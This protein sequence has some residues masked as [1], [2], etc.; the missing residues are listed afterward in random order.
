[1][2]AASIMQSSTSSSQERRSL[3]HKMSSYDRVAVHQNDDDDDNKVA[4]MI[5]LD[6]VVQSSGHIVT[7]TPSTTQIEEYDGDFLQTFTIDDD[8]DDEHIRPG[9]SFDLEHGD[10]GVAAH[11]S[12]ER[13]LSPPQ[14]LLS[15]DRPPQNY[16]CPLTLQVMDDP[17]NDGCG[18]CFER[19]AILDWLEYRQVCPISRKPL[20][21]DGLFRNGSLK[22]RIQEWKEEH[23]LYQ[24]LDEH[25]ADRQVEDM[26]SVG[27]DDGRRSHSNFELMLLPQERQVLN[28]VKIR[29]YHRRKREEFSRCM[30][31]LG[32]T[33]T[34]F[35][36]GAT[37]LAL[38][39]LDMELRGP[40]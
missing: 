29:A 3:F 25:Y 27:S 19:R 39:L 22:F 10:E 14:S 36:V 15:D 33:I 37:V 32:I 18:H 38:V 13:S 8:D 34:V 17:V 1:M 16:R 7:S 9:E 11:R 12:K 2:K 31:S 6:E 23:P 26:L 35:V 40:L 28:I 5:E 4:I 20:S 21:E 30:W 24:H